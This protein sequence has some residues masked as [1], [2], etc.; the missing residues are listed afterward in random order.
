[1][2]ESNKNEKNRNIIISLV[3]AKVYIDLIDIFVTLIES[4]PDGSFKNA[5]SQYLE[6]EKIIKNIKIQELI[7][8][9]NQPSITIDSLNDTS[10]SDNQEHYI[11]DYDKF[12]VYKENPIKEVVNFDFDDSTIPKSDIPEKNKQQSETIFSALI[13]EGNDK[14]QEQ[15]V[16]VKI[17]LELKSS[18]EIIDDTIYLDNQDTLYDEQYDDDEKIL[19]LIDLDNESKTLPTNRMTMLGIKKTKNNTET[20]L[21]TSDFYKKYEGD[22]NSKNFLLKNKDGYDE[23]KTAAEIS[24]MIIKKEIKAEFIKIIPNSTIVKKSPGGRK[25]KRR[26]RRHKKTRKHN[27]KRVSRKYI[28]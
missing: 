24:V 4:Y 27:K 5:L 13:K 20:I 12:K 22:N 9:C 23:E 2:D 6:T 7:K 8:S 25:T 28:R 17:L 15:N 3:I 19:I 10:D 21:T 11:S 1:L 14:I 26:T 16:I 18:N